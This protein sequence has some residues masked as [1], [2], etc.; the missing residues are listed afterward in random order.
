MVSNTS[1]HLLALNGWVFFLLYMYYKCVVIIILGNKA[2][3]IM[4]GSKK[5]V[6]FAFEEAIGFM[7]N[8]AILDKDGIQAGVHLAT[9]AAYLNHHG[10]TLT[11]HL[12]EIYQEYGY[13][14]TCNSYFKTNDV[15]I[16]NEIFHRLR[17]YEGSNVVSKL[18]QPKTFERNYCIIFI[19][20]ACERFLIYQYYS[21]QSVFTI[22][23][24]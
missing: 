18:R 8:T 5:K 21:I 4:Q 23:I 22:H 15:S 3:E 10:I 12:D 17:N 20:Y 1:R 13:H 11:A 2:Y 16:F 9:L 19:V 6:I 7:W 24:P 14:L